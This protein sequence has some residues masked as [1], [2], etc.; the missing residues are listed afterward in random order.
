[1]VGITPWSQSKYEFGPGYMGDAVNRKH[2]ISDWTEGK[3]C[4]KM[5]GKWVRAL[6]GTFLTEVEYVEWLMRP[7]T[8]SHPHLFKSRNLDACVL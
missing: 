6:V 8:S 5:I 7:I 4:M 2:H 3:N 1:M